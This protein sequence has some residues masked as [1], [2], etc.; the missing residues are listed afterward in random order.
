MEY[1][2]P[3]LIIHGGVVPQ[4]GLGSHLDA[5]VRAGRPTAVT[6]RGGRIQAVGDESLL[7]T[8]GD[9]TRLIDACGGAILP[10]LNDGHLHFAASAMTRHA[11]LSLRGARSWSEIALLLESAAP[12]ASGWI[13][14]AEWDEATLGTGGSEA[15]FSANPKHP[16]VAF[17]ASGH[18]VMVNA[19]GLKRL[20]LQDTTDQV[21]GGIIARD[22]AG[23]PTGRFVDAAMRLVNEGLPEIPE[24]LLRTALTRHQQELHALGITSLTEPGLGPGGLSLMAASCGTETLGILAS[25]A[26]TGELTLRV[27]CLLLF[28][29]TG[30]E[31]LESVEHGLSGGLLQITE[32]IDPM[33]LRIAGVKV[34]ADGIP[35]SG[36]A[37]F[38]DEYRIPCGH[39]HGALVL[40]GQDDAQRVEEFRAILTRIDAAGLQAGVHVT[41]DAA[42]EALIEAVEAL[43]D[44]QRA[45][46]NRHY[47]I[48]GAFRDGS[49]LERVQRAGLGY[50]TNP[51]IRSAA[52]ALMR[53][54]LGEKR[55]A[56][57]QPL[58]SAAARDLDVSIAS[59]APV[60]SPDWR[61]SVIAAVT[62]DTTAGPGDGD[63]ERLTIAQ[64]LAM[65][66]QTPARQDHAENHKGRIAAGYLADLCILQGPIDADV[67]RLADNP[68]RHTL[69]GGE[70]VY[71]S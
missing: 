29:G 25:M 23:Q 65:M 55:F 27:N 39:G 12:D 48:H 33:R 34:F 22:T 17:D 4:I 1:A 30:G 42:T 71:S 13:R 59:D 45:R 38:H 19:E 26:R 21:P 52:G 16:I 62:R 68:T 47:I 49:L 31:S 32:G 66:T 58:A 10:G 57:Q 60:T 15:L 67:T 50:S 7:S 43:P 6:V 9:R 69:V 24:Q 51:A 3:D 20:G 18:Q 64:A 61:Q 36:T 8:A 46:R 11:H 70:L 40:R 44:A 41:G 35:R 14:A 37:W 53:S 56:A 63:A 2:V 28:G 5:A 54:L